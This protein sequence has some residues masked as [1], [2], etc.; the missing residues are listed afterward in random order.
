[1]GACS[2]QF[3]N[4]P[5]ESFTNFHIILKKITIGMLVTNNNLSLMVVHVSM[6]YSCVNFDSDIILKSVLFSRL[7][8]LSHILNFHKTVNESIVF[9]YG[10]IKNIFILLFQFSEEIFL[11]HL[12]HISIKSLMFLTICV[13]QELPLSTLD[14]TNLLA[15]TQTYMFERVKLFHFISLPLP[16]L[17]SFWFSKVVNL[18]NLVQIEVSMSVVS[19]S[20]ALMMT[21]GL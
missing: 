15:N 6:I 12:R 4:L 3:K 5:T 7:S 17:L 21:R 13:I 11:T 1:M 2:F 9:M 19:S 8:F 14:K 10:Y 18:K 16:F 20:V